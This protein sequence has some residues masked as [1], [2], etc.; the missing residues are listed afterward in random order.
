VKLL[1]LTKAAQEVFLKGQMTAGHAIL[2][3]RLTPAEQKRAMDREGGGLFTVEHLLWDPDADDPYKNDD[4]IKPVSVREFE[5]WIDQHVKFDRAAADPMLFPET[6]ETVKA[7]VEKAETVVQITH[8]SYVQPEARDGKERIYGPRSWKEVTGKKGCPKAV[9]GVIVAGPG[10]GAA[11]KV[12][13]DKKGC[14]VHWAAEQKEA[15]RRAAGV[16]REGKTEEERDRRRQNEEEQRAEAQRTRWKKAEPAIA[17]ALAAAVQK[18]SARATGLLAEIVLDQCV[19]HSRRTKGADAL[20]S[21]G[22]TAEDFIR[23]AAFQV[24][25][26][27]LDHWRA[28][29]EFPKRA[30]AFGLDVKKI[31]DE[32][33]PAPKAEK[34]AQTSGKKKRMARS[35]SRASSRPGTAGFAAGARSGSGR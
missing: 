1:S 8:E 35:A 26:A 31:V 18:A 21:R 23:Y 29:V 30:K 20:F 6:V 22:T 5:G 3:A 10:R 28:P 25:C 14:K 13:I 9:T 33:A 4:A 16:S 19:N 2:L 11:F 12:C 32:V 24:L 17:K 15:K 34:P 27:Q 7:A